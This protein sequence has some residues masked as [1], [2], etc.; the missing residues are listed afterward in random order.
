[1][2]YFNV[3]TNGSDG[4]TPF[5]YMNSHIGKRF[6]LGDDVNGNV[7]SLN[8]LQT[9]DNYGGIL[10][11]PY[12]YDF[13]NSS[14]NSSST[15]SSITAQTGPNLWNISREDFFG[16][17]KFAHLE[18]TVFDCSQ[19]LFLEKCKTPVRADRANM[20]TVISTCGMVY[21]AVERADEAD[22]VF[23]MPTVNGGF[24]CTRVPRQQRRP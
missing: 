20:S 23:P 22:P 1:M 12:A 7:L 4:S 9:Q 10:S 3:T 2:L 19:Y 17:R 18:G 6:D 13:A 16:I 14:S 24:R 5:S 11:V 21:G 15:Y 8:S